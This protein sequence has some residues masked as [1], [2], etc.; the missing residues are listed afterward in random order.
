[1]TSKTPTLPTPPRSGDVI[2]LHRAEEYCPDPFADHTPPPSG[3]PVG[4]DLEAWDAEDLYRHDPVVLGPYVRLVGA[5]PMG[6]VVTGRAEVLDRIRG[7]NPLVGVN[8]ALFDLPALHVHEGIPVEETIPRAH[9]IRFVAFQDD[10][11]TSYETKDGPG[12]KR[13]NLESLAQRYLGDHKSD[14]GKALADEYGGWGHIA[15][16]D[17]RYHE[18]C[19][20]DVIKALSWPSVSRRC[21]P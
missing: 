7:D 19:Q 8:L 4:L 3:T 10:P 5:G 13:Y 1:M 21:S 20:D 15:Y 9:D 6:D 16:E 14:L 17:A 18:Y 11:P 12:F 2:P